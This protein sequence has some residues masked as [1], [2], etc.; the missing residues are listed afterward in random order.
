M[1]A[2]NEEGVVM[3]SRAA[4]AGLAGLAF[5]VLTIVG[6]ILANFPGGNYSAHAAADYIARGHHVAVF[7]AVYLLL[8]GTFALIWL[9]VYLR[10]LVF[11][12]AEERWL[13]RLFWGCAVA[14]A[15]VLAVG[16]SLVCGVAMATAYGGRSVTLAP[17]VTF[18][19]V[20]TGSAAVWGGGAILLGCALITLAVSMQGLF[21]A[22]LRWAT[23][24]AGA[25][26][27]LGVAFFPSALLI[28]WGIVIGVWLLLSAQRIDSSGGA[29]PT[30]S[31]QTR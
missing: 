4:V 27:L 15:A 30:A 8:L 9:L 17:N 22:W 10:D 20:E 14:A 13:A 29:L 23:A 31:A 26:G 21:P 5:S 2:T 1:V 7:V 6:L 24:V 28:V 25:G 12:V 16:W 11:G 3:R 19:L 18:M